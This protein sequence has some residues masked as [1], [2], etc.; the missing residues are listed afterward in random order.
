M[1]SSRE[2][3]LQIKTEIKAV[4]ENLK[5]LE[6]TQLPDNKQLQ[7]LI[8]N[9]ETILTNLE[10]KPL[11]YIGKA[12]RKRQNRRKRKNCKRKMLKA[13][14][15]DLLQDNELTK[16]TCGTH[17][18]SDTKV[19]PLECSRK[20]HHHL[21]T[22]HECQKFLKTFELLEELHLA[23][24]QDAEK[25]R[26]FAS[27]LQPLKRVWNSMLQEKQNESLNN[28]K[29]I[30]EQWNCVFFGRAEKTFLEGKTD[31]EYFIRKRHIWDS[32][33]DNKYGT[34]I[35]IGWVLPPANPSKEWSKY[36]E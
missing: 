16:E 23:R 26:I 36:L 9:T 12:L 10:N 19:T 32:Y 11:E 20:Y 3:I 5:I 15:N 31:E 17:T 34:S 7:D 4:Q 27:K 8:Y 25:T 28:E 24:G 22:L 1:S 33:I 14:Q 13:T 29:Q 21:R 6:S 2:S 18:T 35:P 30:Q